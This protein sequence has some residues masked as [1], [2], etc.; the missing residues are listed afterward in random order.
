MAD[1][2]TSAGEARVTDLVTGDA[3][4]SKY[5][6]GW[7][8]ATAAAAKGSTKLGAQVGNRATATSETQPSA[9]KAQ[10]VK[11]LTATKVMTVSEAGLFTTSATTS[12]AMVIHSSFTGIALATDDQITF[13]ISLE[14]T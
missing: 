12:G 3:T 4:A 13:T 10:W 2:F 1:V 5:W 8:T 11:T 14:M 6:I 7:G 9:D